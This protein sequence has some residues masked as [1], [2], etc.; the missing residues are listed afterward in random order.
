MCGIAGL[1]PLD[2]RPRP[3]WTIEK[4]VDILYHR[5]PNMSGTYLDANGLVQLGQRRLSI[6]DLSENGRQPMS[7]AEAGLVIVYNGEIFN[8]RELREELKGRGHVF[9]TDT[10]TEVVLHGYAEYGESVVDRLNGMWAFA[11]YDERRRKCFISRDR[12]GIKPIYYLNRGGLF[13]FASEV[14]GII[15]SDRYSPEMD[16]EGLNEYMTFQNV[17][18]NRTLFKDV[19]MLPAG[20]NMR[21]DVDMAKVETFRYWDMVYNPDNSLS[22]D[23]CAE[24]LMSAFDRAMQR[25]VIADVPVGATVSGGMDSSAIVAIASRHINKLNT[26]TGFFDTS[27]V[28]QNE[29]CVSEKD[30]ARI[31]ATMFG[32]RH[33]ERQITFND[34]LDTMPA[35]VWYLEDPKVGMCYTFYTMAQMVASNVTVNLSGTGGDELFAGYPWRYSQIDHVADRDQFDDIYF[36]WWTRLVPAKEKKDLFQPGIFGEMDVATPASEFRKITERAKDYA[37]LNRAL[38]YDFKTFLHGFL[39]VEDKMGMAYSL[40]TRFPFLDKELL[41]VMSKIPDGYKYKNGE[42]KYI[43]KKAFSKLLPQ[44]IL[45]KRKQGFTPPDMTWYRR[46]LREYLENTLLGHRSLS[47]E[48]FRPEFVRKTLDDHNNGKDNRLLIWS[49]LF[50]EGWCRTFLNGSKYKKIVHF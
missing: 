32:T 50:V 34:M 39:M 48:F 14:K 12:V 5:G 36:K 44:D 16:A 38:Y 47:S 49:M 24:M 13:M 45:H 15:A 33:H 2:K 42:A 6:I 37:P 3:S 1:I 17:I 25:H 31:I 19:S 41:D 27:N 35:I 11:I 22:E 23:D 46:E 18:S 8:Y 29:R 21:I 4:M 9:S 10:D 7:L 40:E 20:C 30:D 26:F 28:M 43:L